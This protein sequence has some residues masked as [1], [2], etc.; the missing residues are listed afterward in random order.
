MEYAPGMPRHS[1]SF[2]SSHSTILERVSEEAANEFTFD[3]GVPPEVEVTPPVETSPSKV[4]QVNEHAFQRLVMDKSLPS[5]PE[6]E[7]PMTVLDLGN[8]QADNAKARSS[9]YSTATG[10]GCER[11]SQGYF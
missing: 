10:Q 5:S 2:K 3:F 9:I 4:V 1:K 7:I 6:H 8:Y 11:D